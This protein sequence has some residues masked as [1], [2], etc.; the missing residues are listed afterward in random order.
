MELIP[1]I[2]LME[3][4]CVRLF[5]GKKEKKQVFSNNPPEMALNFQERGAKRLHIVDL[6]GAFSGEIK[7]LSV[8]EEIIEKIDIPIQVG[9]GIRSMDKISSLLNIGVDRVILGTKAHADEGFLK[10]CLEG[11]SEDKIL[12]GVDVRDRK[13]SIKGWTETSNTEINDFVSDL[14]TLG[15]KRIIITDISKDGALQGPN[16]DLIKEI[17]SGSKM[18]VILS[19]GISSLT[20]LQ[21]VKEIEHGNFEGVIVGTSLYKNK[22]TLEAALEVLEN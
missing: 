10:K 11:F 1:A 9:G 12:V 21:T 3:G 2:D 15:S 20:D 5:Q 13:V 7:N 6:D 14:E 17:M 8:I 4:C 18:K 16:I 22:F 19:G